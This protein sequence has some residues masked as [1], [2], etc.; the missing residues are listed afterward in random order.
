MPR[1]YYEIPLPL[2]ASPELRASLIRLNQHLL[3]ISQRLQDT[4][5]TPAE[6]SYIEIVNHNIDHDL[7]A[8]DMRKFHIFDCARGNITVT[9]PRG[10]ALPLKTW[11]A[12]AR[13]G[14]RT[15]SITRT[16]NDTVI[17]TGAYKIDNRETR[18][19]SWIVLQLIESD[20]WGV[21]TDRASFGV[22]KLR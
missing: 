12:C 11:V 5:Y 3:D 17:D 18:Y 8:A 4:G 7:S 9:L 21:S 20:Y 16:G 2:D 15:L 22:W 1:E 14:S 10:A 6:E 13:K 19:M